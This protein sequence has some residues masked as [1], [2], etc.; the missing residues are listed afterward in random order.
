MSQSECFSSIGGL[1]R[2]SLE[3][4]IL[5]PL[6]LQESYKA[7]QIMQVHAGDRVGAFHW[8]F[9][10]QAE[11]HFVRAPELYLRSLHAGHVS[12]SR[13]LTPGPKVTNSHAASS[14]P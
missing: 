11:D 2:I 8:L 9:V 1:Q 10:L 5:E 14:Q 3:S 13:L 6:V 7:N 4:E 12:P